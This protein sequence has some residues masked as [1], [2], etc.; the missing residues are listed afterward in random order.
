MADSTE[1]S[2]SSLCKQ[3]D[4]SCMP[5]NSCLICLSRLS[6]SSGISCMMAR[7]SKSSSLPKIIRTARRCIASNWSRCSAVILECQ[8]AH[9][10]SCHWADNGLVVIQEIIRR[11][12]RTFEQLQKIQPFAGFS[13]HCRDGQETSVAET[14]TR[15]RRWP[16]QPRRDGDETFAGLET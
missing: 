7:I 1:F 9:A 2:S 8:T 14:E 11:H 15:P 16:H 5:V 4:E 10:Y 6:A 3:C 13:A 12:S